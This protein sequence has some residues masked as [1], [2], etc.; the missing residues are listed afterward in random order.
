MTDP[1]LT[2]L[3][4]TGR[5]QMVDVGA[6]SQTERRAL[7]E[8]LVRMSPATAR[9]VEAGDAPKGDVLSVA[10]IAGIQAAKQTSVLIPLAHPIEITSVEVDATIDAEQGLVRVVAEA[11][12][13]GRTGI[14]MEVMTACAVAALTIYDMVKGLER[15]VTLERVRLLEKSGGRT[16]WRVED[17]SD[18]R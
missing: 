15:G 10:R 4:S 17:E 8:A 11:R 7:A 9:A 5:A 14:E 6:K 18:Q 12:T 16:D 2:H 1:K 13:I 3:D